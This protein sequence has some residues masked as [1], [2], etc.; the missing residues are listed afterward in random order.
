M[1][2]KK[3]EPQI[4]EDEVR[5]TILK[6]F[7]DAYKNPRGIS[8]YKLKLK[9]IYSD[10]KKKGIERKNVART[11]I[12]FLESG[13]I[14]EEIKEIPYLTVKGESKTYRISKDG[15]NFFDEPSKFQKN[16]SLA[17]INMSNIEN[18]VI[19]FGDNNFI[20]N[21]H[22]DLAESL[23]KLGNQIRISSELSDD[24]KMD[25]QAEINTLKAQLAKSNPNKGII[26]KSWESLKTV[27]TL[28]GVVS[29][30]MKV[31]PLIE[32]LF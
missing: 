3:E 27:S 1:A 6:Y 17:G 11:M 24:D 13:W 21:E 16:N 7:Y 14:I 19:V 30:Y 15:I 26:Q 18:S 28:G 25:Y 4:S 5:T 32:S 8:S 23:G 9:K 2:K 20:R 31:K 12:Y 29:F 10:L 22:K